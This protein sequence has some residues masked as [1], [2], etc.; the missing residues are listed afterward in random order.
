M[1]GKVEHQQVILG[2]RCANLVSPLG[3][4]FQMVGLLRMS[5][6]DAIEA[7]MVFTLGEDGEVQ[8]CGIHLGNSGQMVSRSGDAEHSTRLHHSASCP[9]GSMP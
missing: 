4:E 5:K 9:Y 6:D 1:V 2:G 7:V 3:G 8:P